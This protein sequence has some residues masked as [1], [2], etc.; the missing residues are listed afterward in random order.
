[1]KARKQNLVESITHKVN[2]KLNEMY[3]DLP[4]IILEQFSVILN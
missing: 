3:D 1:M 4:G 2:Q